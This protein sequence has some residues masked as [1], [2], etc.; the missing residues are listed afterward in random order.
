MN[1]SLKPGVRPSVLQPQAN[2]MILIVAGVFAKYGYET[3]VTSLADGRHSRGSK[4]YVG[5]AGDFRTRHCTA[6][7]QEL[8]RAE[9]ADRLGDDYDVVLEADHLHVEYDPERHFA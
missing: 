7:H 6:A 2:L 4:H 9:S 8:I 5:F 3:V 1:I